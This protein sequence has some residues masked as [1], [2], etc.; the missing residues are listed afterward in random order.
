MKKLT[1]SAEQVK[2][3]LTPSEYR[4]F[5]KKNN[6]VK[7][8]SQVNILSEKYFHAD[9]KLDHYQISGET[10][11]RGTHGPETKNGHLYISIYHYL[12]YILADPHKYNTISLG[13]YLTAESNKLPAILCPKYIICKYKAHPYEIHKYELQF[14]REEQKKGVFEKYLS[15]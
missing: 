14:L 11:E 10:I 9:K 13:Y 5:L 15:K 12:E 2:N 4:E 6:Q 3:A 1:L 7:E 8:F